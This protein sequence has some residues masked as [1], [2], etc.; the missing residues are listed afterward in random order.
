MKELI[1]SSG[2]K[3]HFI[4]SEGCETGIVKIARKVAND[5]ERAIGA[6]TEVSQVSGDVSAE[7]NAVQVAFGVV[8]QSKMLMIFV[9]I[10]QLTFP[11]SQEKEKYTDFLYC[12]TKI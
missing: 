5:A 11:R 7:D 9:K 6:V 2:K 10:K 8:G 4:Y 1:I 12:L 3:L